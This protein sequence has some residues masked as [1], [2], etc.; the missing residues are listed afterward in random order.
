VTGWPDDGPRL[1]GPAPGIDELLGPDYGSG[2]T[3]AEIHEA[4][5]AELGISSR[6]RER[7]A[8]LP[9]TTDLRRQLHL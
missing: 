9:D 4:M 6:R 8:D 2:R 1:A 7:P 5:R 3:P